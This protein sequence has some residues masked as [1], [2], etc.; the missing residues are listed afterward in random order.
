MLQ[1]HVRNGTG[2]INYGPMQQDGMT[3]KTDGGTHVSLLFKGDDL[4][5]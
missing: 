4:Y 3:T 2:R 5:K 1:K